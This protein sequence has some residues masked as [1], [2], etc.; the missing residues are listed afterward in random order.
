MKPRHVFIGGLH[1]SGTTLLANLLANHPEATGLVDTGVSK[2]EGQHLQCIY[3]P[4]NELGGVGYFGFHPA[5]Y[6]DETSSLVSNSSRAAL[7]EAWTPYWA[8]SGR[9][10]LVEKSPGNMLR[11]RFLQ[12]LFPE[13]L[14]VIVRRHPVA[15]ALACNKWVGLRLSTHLLHWINC[16]RVWE[17]DR[18]H[19]NHA[20]D[21][22]YEDLVDN[23]RGTL[24]A[25]FDAMGTAGGLG[26]DR[27]PNLSN[28]NEPYFTS[29]ATSSF[30]PLVGFYHDYL[31]F[32]YGKAV[33]HLGYR[34]KDARRSLKA[35]GPQANK[36]RR[37]MKGP[38]FPARLLVRYWLSCRRRIHGRSRAKFG[39]GSAK[40][41]GR[42]NRLQ[43]SR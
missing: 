22:R 29:Y 36:L 34:L 10:F 40:P 5:A 21:V 13:A 43:K 42:Q 31:D 25:I 17:K 12:A 2:D 15:V 33:R 8:S 18:A 11:T 38:S 20:I 27:I 4:D 39:I 14:F 37:M 30:D 1:R 3:L 16:Y 28:L 7:L 26:T 24:N 32:R 9:A 41:S 35:D 6:L 23:L 19:I